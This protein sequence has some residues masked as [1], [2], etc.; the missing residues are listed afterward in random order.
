MRHE[1]RAAADAAWGDPEV[2]STEFVYR[3]AL[4]DVIEARRRGAPEETMRE[5]RRCAAEAHRRFGQALDAA[6]ARHGL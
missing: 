4:V 6:F 1:Q 2:G 3:Y 5:L